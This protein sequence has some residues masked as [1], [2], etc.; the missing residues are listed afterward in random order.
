MKIYPESITSTR[1]KLSRA[2]DPV[3]CIRVQPP[4][5]RRQKQTNNYSIKKHCAVLTAC[6]T[7]RS[8]Q[9]GFIPGVQKEP[10]THF[11]LQLNNSSIKIMSPAQAQWAQQLL[12]SHRM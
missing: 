8:I 10:Q 1:R 2:G 12:K 4:G 11:K 3:R 5:S 7:E 6:N 9:E